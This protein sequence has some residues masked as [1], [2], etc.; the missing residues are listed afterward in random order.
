MSDVDKPGRSTPSARLPSGALIGIGSGVG[1]TAGI[2][3]ATLVRADAGTGLALGA[4][5]GAGAGVVVG[6]VIET[7]RS[8]R[9]ARPRRGGGAGPT[10]GPPPA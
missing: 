6:A 9:P 8:N 1:A 3:L 2:L 7:Y 5:F 10:G 4:A